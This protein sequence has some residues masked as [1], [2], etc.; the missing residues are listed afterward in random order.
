MRSFIKIILGSA[1]GFFLGFLLIFFFLFGKAGSASKK[2]GSKKVSVNSV[3]NLKLSPFIPDRYAD[4]PFASFEPMGFSMS[5]NIG[6]RDLLKLID[7]A[8]ND[9][10][11]KGIYL[12]ADMLMDGHPTIYAVRNVL[13][14]FK[15]SG[16]FIVANHQFASHKSYLLTSVA[17]EVYIHPAGYFE[18]DGF[19]VEKTYLK[20]LFDKID[21]KPI[22]LYSGD[23]KS[24]SETFRNDKMSEE[25][26]EQTRAI[27]GELYDRFNVTISL[28]RKIPT[29]S[30]IYWANT[31]AI[32][33]VNTALKKKLVDGLKFED[34]IYD[35]LKSKLGLKEEDKLSLVSIKEY[36]KV[37]KPSID[38]T[39]DKIAVV[40]AEGDIVMGKGDNSNI[41]GDEYKDLIRNLRKDKDIKA[42]VLRINSGGGSAFASDLIWRELTLFKKEKPLV[43]S[44]GNYAASGGY[45]VACMADSIFADECTITGSIG[46]VG[47]MFNLTDFF[48]NKLGITFDREGTGPY[49]DFGNPNREW[50]EKELEVATHQ[51][52][53]IYQDFKSK[54]AE[55]RNMNEEDVE[56]SAQGRVWTGNAALAIGLVD[57]LG[58]LDDA[59]KSAANLAKLGEFKTS[60]YPEEKDFITNF[61]NSLFKSKVKQ[62]IL[63]EFGPKAVEVYDYIQLLSQPNG[64]YTIMPYKLEI[65]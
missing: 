59:I 25:D 13:K 32:V 34:E 60:F 6:L 38:I 15:S 48:K 43:V 31:L 39:K 5:A 7:N 26:R 51:V 47:I 49:A 64:I 1:I 33:D 21:V 56:S 24:F 14:D 52:S 3:L 65:N 35:I 54:V 30:L 20:G 16:K 40:Y 57:K 53:T 23:Y 19:S 44:M 27:L 50:T 22:P 2:S 46:V 63:K 11:I 12:E 9:D 29:D 55:G 4:N 61:M 37:L 45:Y 42:L 36:K 28:D 58:T 8:K 10:N 62:N 18:L 17:D 41:G